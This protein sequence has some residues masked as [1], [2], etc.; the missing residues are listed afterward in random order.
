[1]KSEKKIFIAFLLNLIFS[2]IELIGG[3]FTGSIAIISDA[4]HD[5]GDATSIGASFFLEK[6]SKKRPDNNYTYGYARFSVLGGLITTIILL[7]GS[8]MV[9]YNAIGRIINPTTINYNGMLILAVLGLVVNVLATHFTHG[10]HSINQKA[11]NLH[12]LEDVFGWVI[13]LVGAIVIKFT[14]FYLLDPILSIGV[15]IFVL[16]NAVKYLREILEILL[17]KTPK[18]LDLE[19]IKLH[20]LEIQGVVDVHSM[21]ILSV[22][23]ENV[24][25]TLHVVCKVLDIKIKQE[26][27]SELKSHGIAYATVELELTTENHKSTE[28]YIESKPNKHKCCHHHH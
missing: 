7:I 5:F 17:I 6:K 9:I 21:Q 2:S 12:M 26:V 20:L 24:C 3:I 18:N 28:F 13:I 19:Q 23:N 15:A 8:G 27:K 10:G 25:A 16:I 14:K 22:D 1:M 4:I 11:I